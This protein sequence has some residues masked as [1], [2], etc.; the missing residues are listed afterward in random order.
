M[1]LVTVFALLVA[2]SPL[3]A[4]QIPDTTSAW[5]YFPLHVGDA[6][7]YDVT[8]TQDVVIVQSYT[9]TRLVRK[10]TLVDGARYVVVEE[11]EYQDSPPNPTPALRRFVV[12]FDTASARI[13]LADGYAFGV[14]PCPL[15]APFPPPEGISEVE[16]GSEGGA[17]MGIVRDGGYDESVSVGSEMY[18]RAA[19]T[20]D[21]NPLIGAEATYAADL[22]LVASAYEEGNSETWSLRTA[23]IEGV[24]YGDP[25]EARFPGIPDPTDPARYYPLAVGDT[26]HYRRELFDEYVT[27]R[28]VTRD[29]SVADTAYAVVRERV[30]LRPLGS[31]VFG[32]EREGEELLRYDSLTAVFMSGIRS[33]ETVSGYSRS[34]L[35]LD[36]VEATT[37]SM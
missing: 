12:R 21:V 36:H 7:Q 31:D 19:K 3:A 4:A 17:F 23:R 35:T 28:E 11:R 2:V 30:Y 37:A 6:W 9:V 32:L 24:E 8:R 10:D 34:E 16:C 26:W 18:V 14:T 29:T 1:R 25:P 20:I 13:V 5:R 22:G 15:D 33:G 27:I